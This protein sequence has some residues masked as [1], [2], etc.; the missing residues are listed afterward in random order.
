MI[1]IIVVT[2]LDTATPFIQEAERMLGNQ[3]CVMGL[4]LHENESLESLCQHLS[5]SIEN[6]FKEHEGEGEGVLILTDLFGSSPTNACL[7]TLYSSQRPIEILTGV[8]LPMVISSLSY[9]SR[10]PL[11]ELAEKVLSDGQKG[12][13]HAVVHV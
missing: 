1:G 11:K 12:I 8:N 3:K 9:R 7:K 6:C 13:K 5:E 2:H 10:L 4:N